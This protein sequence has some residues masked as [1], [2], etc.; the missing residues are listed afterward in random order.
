MTS[1]AVY[2]KLPR[3]RPDDGRRVPPAAGRAA[4]HGHA[5]P[6]GMSEIA[7]KP[8]PPFS[9]AGAGARR[10]RR[11]HARRRRSAR[12]VK[13]DGIERGLEALLVEAE[14]RARASASPPREFDRQKQRHAARL[15]ARASPSGT[16][17]ESA[18]SRP[19]SSRNFTD[20]E[21]MPGDRR[22]STGSCQR[23]LPDDHARRGEQAREG[24]F[25]D[26]NRVV[27]V[28]APQKPGLVLP[29][30]AKLR[31]RDR[32]RRPRTSTQAYVDTAAGAVADR[33][34]AGAGARSSR[35]TTTRRGRHHR[36]G[37]V[38]RR[39]GRPEADHVQAGRGG[40]P[41]DEPR[42]HV[43]RERRRLRPGAATAA[44]V[45]AAGGLGKF[46]AI[47]LRNA[48]G[49][50]GRVG[51]AVHRRDRTRARAAARSPKDLE[52][53]FQ[54]IYLNVHRAARRPGG[55]RGADVADARRCS[56][57]SRRAPSV[58]RSADAAVDAVAEPPARR[59]CMTAEMVD[60]MDL[61]K[62][63]AFYKDRFADASDFTFVFVG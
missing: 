18:I 42:R 40:V 44:Q 9:P 55:L 2:N 21:P 47:Q 38:Q 24:W 22:T 6:R 13:E 59:A 45:V 43:A 12:S 10:L 35:T 37:A 48:A 60:Q 25:S 36:V 53:M 20:S 19:S 50:Q 61:D 46:N 4:L 52:T 11:A 30:A 62:S 8:D 26:R 32:E 16:S 3:P 28:S 5:Q 23:F 34:A 29:D 15:R 27:I 41:R 31:R 58:R 17:E 33:Q 14:S 57:T 1:V 7:Q 39:Q 56:P 51:D 49:G 63:L 54:L